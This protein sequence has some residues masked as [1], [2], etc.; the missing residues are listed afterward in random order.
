[1]ATGRRTNEIGAGGCLLVVGD[2]VMTEQLAS[3]AYQ[4]ISGYARAHD[5]SRCWLYLGL[6]RLGSG[7]LEEADRCWEQ[8]E[9]HWRELG[10]PL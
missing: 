2:H 8:A 6:T 1:M 7:A 5:V 4:V 10:K 9:Q 3:E